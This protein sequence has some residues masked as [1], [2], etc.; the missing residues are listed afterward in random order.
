MTAVQPFPGWDWKGLLTVGFAVLSPRLF[1]FVPSGDRVKL[2]SL[3][4]AAKNQSVRLESL[5]YG[6]E[7][8][9]LGKQ[10]RFFLTFPS[11]S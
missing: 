8:P 5:T 2:S 3:T 11:T 9:T 10:L 4:P 7:Y 1:T 6:R